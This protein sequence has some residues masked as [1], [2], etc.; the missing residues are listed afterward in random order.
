MC[1]R[2]AEQTQHCASVVPDSSADST[3]MPAGVE[4]FQGAYLWRRIVPELNRD[5]ARKYELGGGRADSL[6]VG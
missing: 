1:N 5:F 2:R 4:L 6:Y 3:S